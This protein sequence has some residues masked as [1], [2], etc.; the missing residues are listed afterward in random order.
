MKYGLKVFKKNIII[1]DDLHQE[2]CNRLLTQISV[3]SILLSCNLWFKVT[4]VKTK[5]ELLQYFINR[6]KYQVQSR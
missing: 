4:K 6:K 5:R 3:C 1:N 2:R